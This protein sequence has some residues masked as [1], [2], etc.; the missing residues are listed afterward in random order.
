MLSLTLSDGDCRAPR[1]G[2]HRRSAPARLSGT[3]KAEI[4]VGEEGDG[5]AAPSFPVAGGWAVMGWREGAR[6][7]FG[8]SR[9]P[10]WAQAP[11]G[12]AEG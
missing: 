12:C 5:A 7:G 10:A 8:G 2:R 1:A 9:L 3:G 6:L 4:A 11:P